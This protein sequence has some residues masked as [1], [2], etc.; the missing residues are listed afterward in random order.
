MH[1]GH[2]GAVEIVTC[3]SSFFKS[4]LTD[5]RGYIVC[6]CA[7]HAHAKPE[8]NNEGESEINLGSQLIFSIGKKNLFHA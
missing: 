6:L 5:F 8:V 2:A 4:I 1:D 7:H 3:V